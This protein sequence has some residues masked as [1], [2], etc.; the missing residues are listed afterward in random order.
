MTTITSAEIDAYVAAVAAALTHLP[1]A[2]QADLLED[3]PDH[4]AEILGEG[5]DG[6]LRERLGDPATY[7]AELRS[8]AGYPAPGADGESAPRL[9]SVLA[10]LRSRLDRTDLFMG[11][12]LGYRR[13]REAAR[14]LQ[15][16]WWVLRGWLVA[17]ILTGH[18]VSTHPTGYFPKVAGDGRLGALL[19]AACIGA[20]V[21]FGRATSRG[22]V[23]TRTL[24]T[25]ASITIAIFGL[26]I[27][28]NIARWTYYY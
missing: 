20:S 22:T 8:A 2:V 27:L 17:H 21:R 7:A 10:Q 18:F 15:P 23:Q 25:L 3:L 11:R 12:L 26:Y 19:V 6:T 16:G 13:A 28:N 4:L 9:A 5:D 1:G 14:A 24:A